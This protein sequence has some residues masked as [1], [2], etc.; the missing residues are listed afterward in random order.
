MEPGAL[1][2]GTTLDDPVDA[3]QKPN[4]RGSNHQI[5]EYLKDQGA[6][7][8]FNYLLKELLTRQPED[9]LEHMLKCLQTEY[10]LGPLKVIVSAPPCVGRT[11]QA[12]SLAEHF[13][14]EYIGA[15]ELLR[16]AGVKT[17]G[18][19]YADEA[20]TAELVMQR[21]NQASAEMRGFVLDGFPRT[22]FQTSF[23]KDRSVVPSHVL[24]LTASAEQ[25][26]RRREWLLASSHDSDGTPVSEEALDLKLRLHSCHS[27]SALE[28]YEDKISLVPVPEDPDDEETLFRQ[29][30][31][32][33]RTLPRSRG[34]HPPPRVVILGPR[35][36]G[37]K[38]HASRLAARLGAV[39][40]DGAEY[41]L[42]SVTGLPSPRSQ[43]PANKR[44]PPGVKKATTLPILDDSS[45]PA[46]P[47]RNFSGVEMPHEERR[48]P[49]GALG[50]RLRDPDC[51]KQGWV[52]CGF[53]TTE[54][55]AVALSDD[56]FLAP[57][58][59]LALNASTATCV[60]RL[61]NILT[62]AVTGKVWTTLPKNETIRKRLLRRAEDHP[63]AVR[64]AHM[65]HARAIDGILEALNTG[66]QCTQIA[67][68]GAPEAV[69]NTIV[70]FVER[71][72]PLPPRAA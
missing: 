52:I 6:Y 42:D 46:S 19:G 13:G 65:S 67:A 8:I 14:L 59:V 66:G 26:R 7:D 32:R 38:E 70:E 57:T 9:P 1:E 53:P 33:V 35:G 41:P 39:F 5:S 69:H 64:E 31:S 44:R 12:R 50:S 20:M 22:R 28:V 49:L 3:D 58:R 18:L 62:D 55:H 4:L 60:R 24:V 47:I 54:E 37:S 2:H 40:V 27:S 10:P 15:G 17:D 25:I 51:S 11:T 68:D 61:R 63:N 48:D 71:P 34:P 36:I 30:E 72:L 56:A 43:H 45:R 29:L 16:E 21:V 23:L